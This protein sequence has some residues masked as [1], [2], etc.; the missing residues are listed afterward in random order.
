MYVCALYYI[1]KKLYEM[2]YKIVVVRSSKNL[3][4][5]VKKSE[6]NLKTVVFS[7]E[8]YYQYIDFDFYARLKTRKL[9]F[10]NDFFL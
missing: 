7:Y 9:K 6:S 3:L 1:E 5:P 10:V 2:K 4:E 8:M